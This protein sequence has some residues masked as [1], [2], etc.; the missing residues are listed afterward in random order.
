MLKLEDTPGWHGTPE[1]ITCISFA[2]ALPVQEHGH[3]PSVGSEAKGQPNPPA[4][5]GGL[6]YP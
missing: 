5:C 2:F 6:N 1:S 4:H 3:G